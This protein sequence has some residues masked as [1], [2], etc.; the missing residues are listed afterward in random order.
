MAA[1]LLLMKS[2]ALWSPKPAAFSADIATR[3]TVDPPA[4][5]LAA[6]VTEELPPAPDAELTLSS[7]SRLAALRFVSVTA[8][9]FD[10][11]GPDG[12]APKRKRTGRLP[13]PAPP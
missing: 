6:G 7:R 9:V 2:T 4:A 3:T 10:C 13:N 5:T 1:P 11:A 8:E 12:T